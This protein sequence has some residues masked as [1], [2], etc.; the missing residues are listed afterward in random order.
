MSKF[1]TC[2]KSHRQKNRLLP[3]VDAGKLKAC[4]QDPPQVTLRL[5]CGIN[6]PD[7]PQVLTI[8]PNLS[9]ASIRDPDPAR[10]GTYNKKASPH[11]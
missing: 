4:C 10:P 3:E 6:R 5:T 7:K 2:L 8:H 1:S 11:C 9:F